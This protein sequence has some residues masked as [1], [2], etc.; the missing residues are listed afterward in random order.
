[1][2]RET[3]LQRFPNASESFIRNNIAINKAGGETSSAKP[4]QVV[5]VESMGKKE[6][7]AGNTK[8]FSRRLV[9]ITSYRRRLLDFDN[10]TGGCKYFLDSCKYSGLIPDDRPQDIAV[11]VVQVKVKSKADERTEI[12]IAPCP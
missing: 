10:L 2:T 11:E 3:L 6:G 12:T 1:M 8:G 7:K 5:R 9:R 4:E